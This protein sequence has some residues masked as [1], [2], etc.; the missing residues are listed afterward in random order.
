IHVAPDLIVCLSDFY[1]YEAEKGKGSL[2]LKKYGVDTDKR[3]ICFQTHRHFFLG[4]EHELLRELQYVQETLDYE[5][6]F[7]PIGYCHGDDYSLRWLSSIAATPFKYIPAYSIYDMISILAASDAFVGTS[8]HGN[9]TAFSF[10]LPHVFGPAAID[11]AEGFLEIAGLPKELKMG[12]WSELSEKLEFAFS[13]DKDSI[14][15]KLN[16]SKRRVHA[17]FEELTTVYASDSASRIA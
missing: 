2:I 10:G 4:N 3:I 6:I 8:L 11:K 14:C 9:I 15:Q 12:N 16:E 7:M 13:L 1:N 17:T 5:V